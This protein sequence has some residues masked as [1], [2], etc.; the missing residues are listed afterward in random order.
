MSI[1]VLRMVAHKRGQE[2]GPGGGGYRACIPPLVL[3]QSYPR[4]PESILPALGPPAL[5]RST[6]MQQQAPRRLEGGVLGSRRL[7]SLG[8][9]V[10]LDKLA[11]RCHS[12]FGELRWLLRAREGKNRVT[13]R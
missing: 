6:V 10:L 11:Q 5:P 12:F 9:V 8:E 3:G 7:H 1:R 4:I 13:I 2:E